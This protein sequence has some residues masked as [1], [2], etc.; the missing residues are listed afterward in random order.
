LVVHELRWRQYLD[1]LVQFRR[2]IAA[3]FA[4][5]PSEEIHAAR[6][7]TRP[8]TLAQRIGRH[9]RFAI[10]RQFADE[11]ATMQDVSIINVRVNKGNK[12]NGYDVFDRAWTALL[13]R[14]QNTMSHRNFPGPANPDER[15]MV[16]A[17]HTDGVK[18]TRLVRRLRRYNPLP[19]KADYRAANGSSYRNLPQVNIIE[20]PVL[21]D[22]RYSYFVQAA[23]LAAFLLYQYTE[24]NTYFRKKHG[25]HYWLRLDPVFCKKAATTNPY[26][27]VDL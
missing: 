25:G 5:R 11:L 21:R 2:R 8:G 4:L 26:G 12:P 7:I 19:H 9:D 14:F 27:L 22:S 23:D 10:I 6:F 1:Q 13:Q 15:G 17:D 24:P 3:Q 18:L 16:L 20:D